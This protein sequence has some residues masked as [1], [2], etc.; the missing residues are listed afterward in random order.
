MRLNGLAA[1]APP[2][3]P[4][5]AGGVKA[6][7]ATCCAAVTVPCA[8]AIVVKLS[9]DA[10]CDGRAAAAVT[11][12]AQRTIGHARADHAGDLDAHGPQA[13]GSRPKC[14][15][16]WIAFM[17]DAPDGNTLRPS[18]CNRRRAITA[19]LL[20]G[21]SLGAL[22]AT[23]VGTAMP[24]VIATLGGLAHYS[25]VFSA[26]LLTSTASVP[27]WGRLSDLYGRRR[28]YLT[29]IAIFLVG[30]MMSGAATSMATLIAARAVQGLGTG[31]HHPAQHDDRRRALHA[32]RARQDAGALQRR[33]GPGSVAGPLVGGYITD[34]LSWRW[35]FYLNLPFGLM[36]VAVIAARVS[37]G[38]PY[39]GRA[40]GLAGRERCLFAGISALLI[41]LGA[42]TRGGVAAGFGVAAVVLLAAFVARRAARAGADPAARPAAAIR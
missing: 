42:D 36:A 2:A 23:V 6:P 41:A 26:Y 13:P 15:V 35:V 10:A 27:I 33:V 9:H 5:P 31:A 25:W 38:S 3:R 24:T 28:M 8:T 4:G 34:A 7:A 32:R 12:A 19:G 29:G 40:R 30:S 11:N 18:A 1:P 20:L 17:S 37:T 39:R 22:E 16:R 21:M 14:V